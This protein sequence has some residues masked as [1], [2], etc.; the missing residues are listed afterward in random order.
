M[1]TLFKLDLKDLAKGLVV[2]VLSAILTGLYQALNA[3]AI[4]DPKQLLLIGATAGVGY[5]IKNFFTDSSGKL[6][7]V[8]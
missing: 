7:G 2:A 4:I 8:L 5:L 3:Q 1:S 6:G